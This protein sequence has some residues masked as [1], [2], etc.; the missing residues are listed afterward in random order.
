MIYLGSMGA[1]K[2]LTGE[3]L[4]PDAKEQQEAM[5]KI[6]DAEALAVQQSGNKFIQL[7]GNSNI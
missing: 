4:D 7:Q 6:A 5:Q 3:E 2:S 1:K